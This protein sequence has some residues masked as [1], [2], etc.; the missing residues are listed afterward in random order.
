MVFQVKAYVSNN[1][2]VFTIEADDEK[3]VPAILFERTGIEQT[4]I[5]S[6]NPLIEIK[7]KKIF[8]EPK[9]KRIGPKEMEMFCRQLHALIS[10][11]MPLLESINI[12]AGEQTINKKV[13]N[14][15]DDITVN[16]RSGF[17]F[18]SALKGH[19]DIFDTSFCSTIAAAEE[20]GHLEDALEWLA[21]AYQR[22]QDFNGKM[23]QIL[24]Y[25]AIVVGLAVIITMGLFLFVI[26]K[27]TT[28]LTE[29]GVPIPTLTRIMITIS[30]N[31]H[32]IL[33]S[34]GIIGIIIFIIAK[35]VIAK[36]EDLIR[37]LELKMLKIPVIGRIVMFL[38]TSRL[39]WVM[40]MLLRTG[41]DMLKTMDI[42]IES[43][44]FITLK[45]DLITAKSSLERG[46]LLTESLE[47][48]EWIRSLEL[49]M[50]YIGERSGNLDQMAEHAADLLEKETDII[51]GQL[52]SIIEVF[53]VIM[54][55][56]GVLLVI[57]SMFLPIVDVYQTI[58]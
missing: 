44:N 58:K 57:L 6:V 40:A 2:R 35:T 24:I 53:T 52:P 9:N 41:V 27:F 34:L 14:A 32:W 1:Y 37:K 22:K 17:S 19:P 13:K 55:G 7:R 48:S 39:Y 51:L 26:P 56:I 50:L 10:S 29:G 20:T 33:L 42:L 25:P 31:F 28:L 15:L 21:D 36:N 16:I 54:V 11:G 47:N 12:L 3:Q 38:N 23:R 49:R 4:T 45:D 18:A 43:T 8:H 46:K 5:L 30:R